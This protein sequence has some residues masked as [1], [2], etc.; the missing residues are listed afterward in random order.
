MLLP[1]LILLPSLG[2]GLSPSTNLRPDPSLLLSTDLSPSLILLLSQS[3]LLS[4]EWLNP[5]L[6]LDVSRLHGL[7]LQISRLLVS[8]SL[9]ILLASLLMLLPS[10]L[11][12]LVIGPSPA[13]VCHADEEAHCARP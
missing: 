10:L 9:L 7:R 2:L 6:L 1:S 13:Q 11:L 12:L 8:L 3:P 5:S 4:L